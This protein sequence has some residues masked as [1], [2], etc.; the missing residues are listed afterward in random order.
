MDL[1]I[2]L[3][4]DVT[5]QEQVALHREVLKYLMIPIKAA[6]VQEIGQIGDIEVTLEGQTDEADP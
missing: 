3:P 1:A 2:N 6:E 4:A 5:V